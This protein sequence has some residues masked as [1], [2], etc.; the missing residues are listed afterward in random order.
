MTVGD[1]QTFCGGILPGGIPCT[2]CV[3]R[4]RLPSGDTKRPA[5]RGYYW[6]FHGFEV[7]HCPICGT[8]LGVDEHGNPTRE[9]MMPVS[10]CCPPITSRAEIEK[11]DREGQ[12]DARPI[13]A[14]L[15]ELAAEVPEEEWA[16]A[17]LDRFS[18]AV[19]VLFRVYF[20]AEG[21]EAEGDTDE[22]TAE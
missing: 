8:R 19:A 15:Q 2:A 4:E 13:E 21:S 12:P 20:E 9:A 14:V 11:Q 22:D 7:L 18:A 5:R 17:R 10:A 1:K 16:Q 6:D 3:L